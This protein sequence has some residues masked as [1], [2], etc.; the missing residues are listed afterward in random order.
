MLLK[1]LFKREKISDKLSKEVTF[2][3]LTVLGLIILI[4]VIVSWGSGSNKQPAQ[5]AKAAYP[6]NFSQT[7]VAELPAAKDNQ[8]VELKNGD[9]Y[10]LTASIVKRMV[11]NTEVKALAYNGSVP[12]PT[13]KVAQG[14]EIIINFTN[15]TDVPN[16]IHS[17]GVRLDNAFDGLPDITQPAV[18]VGQSFTYKI[19]FPDAGVFWY[20][21]HIREDYAQPLGLYGMFLVAPTE[22]NYWS[23]VNQEWPV[24]VSDVLMQNNQLAAFDSQAADHTLM[25][26]Y[27][28]ILLVNGNTNTQFQAKQGEVVRM[29]I[30]NAATA[31]PFNL[32]IP[33]VKMKLVGGD[34]GKYEQEQWADSVT[35]GPSE[36]AIVEVMFDR[37]GAFIL[38]NK[39][40]QQETPLATINVLTQQVAISYKTQFETL[41]ANKDVATSIDPFRQYFDKPIDKNLV[42]TLDM[43]GMM[44]NSSGTHQMPNGQMMS[45]GSGGMQS[46][47]MMGGNMAMDN[48]S[49]SMGNDT[50]PIEW[51]DTMGMMNANSTTNTLQWKLVDKDTGKA[52]DQ[53]DWQFKKGDVV[54]ISIYNDPNSMHPMQHPIH[55]HGNR[56][57]VLSTNGVKNTDLVWKDTVL[58]PKGATV[59]LLADMSNPGI[60]MA[61]CHI[62]EH[63]E[64]G[65]MMKFEV[66]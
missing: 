64:S 28:N 43:K 29:Y 27:G 2:A 1:K 18:A 9:T 53:I 49:M 65:M 5:Q 37:S 7:P 32:T 3:D 26:R 6:I 15:N 44:G 22:A 56:F 10:N 33:G 51:D 48:N 25:G 38:E 41:R 34:N 17:H 52:N 39:T 13:I 31:R 30:A 19:K 42:L 24:F 21:P 45:N 36:R 12:G 46:M 54:K 20:H 40:P 59:E 11:G 35:L 60:W 55:F 66:E 63:L 62:A 14:A 50:D 61:H 47:H 58:I 4:G 8:V 57:L 16:T 23:P